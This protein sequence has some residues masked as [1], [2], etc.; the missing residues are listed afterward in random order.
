MVQDMHA[1]ID[2]MQTARGPLPQR[3]SPHVV[4]A[5][6]GGENGGG[7][8]CREADK[9]AGAAYGDGGYDPM[10][11]RPFTLSRGWVGGGE[12]ENSLPGAVGTGTGDEALHTSG[13]AKGGADPGCGKHDVTKPDEL[14]HVERMS[15]TPPQSAMRRTGG[16]PVAGGAA[17]QAEGDQSKQ[18]AARNAHWK[19]GGIDEDEHA[20]SA[21]AGGSGMSGGRGQQILPLPSPPPTPPFA[22][23]RPHQVSTFTP[24]GQRREG[25]GAEAAALQP[26]SA[27]GADDA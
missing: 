5:A 20:H 27:F 2:G 14:A 13:G 8:F 18:G 9:K 17:A 16:G 26:Q 4:V 12:A 1:M 11:A 7:F 24:G 6:A 22:P 3:A 23:S 25:G 15:R 19:E 21:A 10:G